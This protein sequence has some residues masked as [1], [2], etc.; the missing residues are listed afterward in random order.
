MRSTNRGLAPTRLTRR[1]AAVHIVR[2]DSHHR[3]E[4]HDIDHHDI[5]HHDIIRQALSLR[6]DRTRTV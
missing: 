3:I 6:F 5:D 1:P 2:I 4:H